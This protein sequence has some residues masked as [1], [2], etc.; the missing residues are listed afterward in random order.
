MKLQASQFAELFNHM[1]DHAKP[2]TEQ[3]AA[4]LAV[5]R[6]PM[7]PTKEELNRHK[8]VALGRVHVDAKRIPTAAQV[9]TR[10][11][12]DLQHANFKK[13]MADLGGSR[14]IAAST[15]G[16]L[17]NCRENGALTFVTPPS[18]DELCKARVTP[19]QKLEMERK[20]LYFAHRSALA[21]MLYTE[22]PEQTLFDYVDFGPS[23]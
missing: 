1:R 9:R 11:Q 12:T 19:A 8:R 2:Y 16:E 5:V 22:V 10:E 15:E 21:K 13:M 4:D 18:R 17:Y 7:P 3:D 23:L 20:H 14:T 6:A